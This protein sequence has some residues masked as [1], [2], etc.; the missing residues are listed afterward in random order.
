M[1]GCET[2]LSFIMEAFHFF[3][4]QLMSDYSVLQMVLESSFLTHGVNVPLFAAKQGME[5]QGSV[6]PVQDG[7][8]IELPVIVEAFPSCQPAF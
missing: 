6:I 8:D 4:N 5:W 7:W 3:H 2:E 1:A